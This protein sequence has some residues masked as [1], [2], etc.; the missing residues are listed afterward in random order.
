MT[1]EELLAK[2]RAPQSLEE[3]GESLDLIERQLRSG[4]D[5]WER[6]RS[7]LF[8]DSCMAVLLT[9][10]RFYVLMLTAQHMLIRD[11]SQQLEG[12]RAV[13]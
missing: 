11:L 2:L 5:F 4:G 7:S 13:H 10:A 6:E 8:S 9:R 12:R 3:F 1:Y